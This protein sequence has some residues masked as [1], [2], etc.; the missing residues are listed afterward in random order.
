MKALITSVMSIVPN[1]GTNAGK[2]MFKISAS[3]LEVWAFTPPAPGEIYVV[4]KKVEVNGKEYTN[5][6]GYA[7]MDMESKI[8]LV[9][10][11]DANY[12]MAIASLLK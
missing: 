2:Q 4:T 1:K 11:H 9:T 12:S 6:N 7:T 10:K 5:F 8:G 3:D